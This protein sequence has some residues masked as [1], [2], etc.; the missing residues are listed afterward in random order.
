MMQQ[1]IPQ[2]PRSVPP[3]IPG[4]RPMQQGYNGYG[5]SPSGAPSAG[6][7][8]V[9]PPQRVKISWSICMSMLASAIALEF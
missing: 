2:A 6:V 3:P 9:I 8:S 1:Q 7:L 5:A 4:G